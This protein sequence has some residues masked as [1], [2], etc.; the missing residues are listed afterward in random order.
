MRCRDAYWLPRHLQYTIPPCILLTLL[1][2]PLFTRL[3]L[4][5]IV[6]LV[7]IAFVSTIPWDSYLIRTGIWTY[8]PDA[9]LG[10]TL[11]DIPAEELFFFIIQTYGVSVLYC[12]ISKPLLHP[13]YLPRPDN[14]SNWFQ[15]HDRLTGIIGQLLLV[16][17][18]YT[19]FRM[20]LDA[21]T[22][23]YMGLIIVW[24]TPFCLLLWSLQHRFLIRL[25]FSAVILPIAI[26]TVYLWIVDTFALR[27]GTWVI[28]PGTKLGL[29]LW[30]GLEVEEAFFFLATNTMIVMGLVAFDN[31]MAIVDAFPALTPDTKSFPD[32]FTAIRILLTPPLSY[33]TER[34]VGL[35]QALDRLRKKSRS[36]YLAS[37]TFSGRT[38]IDLIL[39]YSFCR[40]ADDLIDGAASTEEAVK[41]IERL[42]LFLDLSYARDQKQELR[43]FVAESF[44]TDSHQALL[45]LPTSYLSKPPLYGLLKGF[46]MDLQFGKDAAA[47]GVSGWPIGT[48]QELD[49][50]GVYVAGTVAELCIDVILHHHAEPDAMKK[51]AALKQAGCR[52]GVALQTVNISRDIAV[53]AQLGRVYIPS[54][55]L[56][57]VEL[58]HEAVLAGEHP[59]KLA[60]L[61]CK[62]LDYAF[63]IYEE[64]RP[65]IE[66]LPVDARGPMRV[67]IESYMEIGR[68]LRRKGYQVVPGRATV[69]RWRRLVVAWSAL[70]K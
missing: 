58:T 59:D 44:P 54:Q 4:Y 17:A 70:S 52:M 5:K 38:R 37:S 23:T 29:V 34:L 13:V 20:I 68:V 39:L 36:F 49:Q 48:A 35:S 32:P 24:A 28:V 25:P 60:S 11:F 65:A 47:S 51:R 7:T 57:E 40:V 15:K 21:G 6:F 41:W 50:Y 2:R 67:A 43:R 16:W 3:E 8:P 55:W 45:L 64:A 46:E 1:Y 31:C 66:E 18:I 9:V 14:A 42:R 56:V 69:P 53:D 22:G 33:E 12:F 62:L 30:D 10:F 61:R 27:R 19:G 26:P 63:A